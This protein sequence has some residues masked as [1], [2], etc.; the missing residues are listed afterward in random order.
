MA[1][2]AKRMLLEMDACAVRYGWQT[3]ASRRYSS[4]LVRNPR[5]FIS[6][7]RCSRVFLALVRSLMCAAVYL[8]CSQVHVTF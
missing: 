2:R 5:A 6:S 7:L 8:I 3:L 1:A 4:S